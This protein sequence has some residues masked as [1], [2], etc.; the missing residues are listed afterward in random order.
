MC[1]LVSGRL[2]YKTIMMAIVVVI[3]VSVI[4]IAP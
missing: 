2:G 3:F 1:F 4:F